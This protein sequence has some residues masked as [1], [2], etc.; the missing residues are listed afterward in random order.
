[1][2][3]AIDL[4]AAVCLAADPVLSFVTISNFVRN[5]DLRVLVAAA[6]ARVTEMLSSLPEMVLIN[7]MSLSGIYSGMLTLSQGIAGWPTI[8]NGSI[9]FKQEWGLPLGSFSSFWDTSS[10]QARRFDRFEKGGD[11]HQCCFSRGR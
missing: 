11:H 8:L 7:E 10:K 1:M 4:V 2:R 9:G 3:L 6:T 5:C